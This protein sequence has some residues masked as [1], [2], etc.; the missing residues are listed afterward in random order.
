VDEEVILTADRLH[1]VDATQA[2]HAYAQQPALFTL[3]TSV[4][5]HAG[6]G[7]HSHRHR[8]DC[9][10]AGYHCRE[11][12]IVKKHCRQEHSAGDQLYYDTHELS[13]RHRR[14]VVDQLNSMNQIAR[15]PLREKTHSQAEHMPDKA[16]R[17]VDGQPHCHE[18][19]TTL[20]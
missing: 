1:R 13:G 8:A 2:V 14:D 3:Q 18:S 15:E 12:R 20:P 16:V 7:H 11:Y 19:E 5:S 6:P 10:Q 4:L 9:P 17:M